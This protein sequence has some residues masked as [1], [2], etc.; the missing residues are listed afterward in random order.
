MR[1]AFPGMSLPTHR[2]VPLAP[3]TRRLT[4]D[5]RII[6]N[7]LAD[8]T[9]GPLNLL[10]PCTLMVGAL[11]LCW[12]AVSSP[13]GLTVWA[14]FYGL[15]AAGIQSLFPAT[16]S[17]LTTDLTKSGTRWAIP[18]IYSPPSPHSLTLPLLGGD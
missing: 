4:V 17:S 13:A 1:L 11:F 6:P 14:V 18:F 12:P 10:I 2:P 15:F 3:T 8:R 16:L 5:S 9:F 7:Y